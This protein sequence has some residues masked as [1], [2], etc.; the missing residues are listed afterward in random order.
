MISP[1]VTMQVSQ[2]EPLRYMAKTSSGKEIIAE[3]SGILGG[4]GEYPN[5]M[6]YL[7]ASIGTCI[8]IKTHI[9]LTKIGNEPDQIGIG[10]KYTRF[11]SP[12]EILEQIHL[13]IT[14]TGH[15]DETV[16]NK[17][18][19]DTMTLSC[20][21]NVMISRIAKVTWEFRVKKPDI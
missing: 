3:P 12:P 20:P 5:P 14:V 6:E 7:I 21:V 19:Q 9:H 15:L 17:A 16:V 8:A 4:K 2:V 1:S 11:Q 13:V 10:M 18:I